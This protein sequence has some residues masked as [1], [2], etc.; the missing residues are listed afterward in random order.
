MVL[1]CHEFIISLAI[2]R[3]NRVTEISTKFPI[4]ILRDQSK[5]K[6]NAEKLMEIVYIWNKWNKYLHC[7]IKRNMI[8][9]TDPAIACKFCN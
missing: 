9:T 8:S 1:P 4:I 3:G 2:M 7:L 5:R 6:E